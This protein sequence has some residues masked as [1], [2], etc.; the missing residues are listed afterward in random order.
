MRR[1]NSRPCIR[2]GTDPP[3]TMG[4]GPEN[5]TLTPIVHYRDENEYK[6]LPTMDAMYIYLAI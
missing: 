1:R 2:F 4:K 6:H 5:L 3:V